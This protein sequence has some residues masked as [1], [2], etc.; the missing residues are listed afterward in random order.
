MRAK[1]KLAPSLTTSLKI[2]FFFFCDLEIVPVSLICFDKSAHCS[3]E[4]FYAA[5]QNPALRDLGNRLLLIIHII[6]KT[7]VSFSGCVSHI[8]ALHVESRPHL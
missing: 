5:S 4:M 8:L 1:V 7:S 6:R 3:G 2:F